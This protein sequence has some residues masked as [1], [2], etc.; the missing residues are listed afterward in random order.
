MGFIDDHG[1]P[2]GDWNHEDFGRTFYQIEK[3]GDVP[4]DLSK[5]EP[6]ATNGGERYEPNHVD[7]QGKPAPILE[8]PLGKF[9]AALANKNFK[10][11]KAALENADPL[12]KSVGNRALRDAYVKSIDGILIKPESEGGYGYG[13]TP[14]DVKAIE[15]G[16]EQILNPDGSIKDDLT[17]EDAEIHFRELGGFD[18]EGKSTARPTKNQIKMDTAKFYRDR[19]SGEMIRMGMKEED[20]AKRMASQGYLEEPESY[21]SGTLGKM[22]KDYSLALQTKGNKIDSEKL[23]KSW[24]EDGKNTI[25]PSGNAGDRYDEIKGN[26]RKMYKPGGASDKPNQ[27]FEAARQR[28]YGADQQ[29]KNLSLQEREIAIREESNE[30]SREDSASRRNLERDKMKQDHEHFLADQEQKKVDAIENRKLQR[31]QMQQQMMATVLQIFGQFVTTAMT[32]QGQVASAHISG[33]YQMQAS[34]MGKFKNS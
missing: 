14:E 31:E 7:E 23:A 2:K 34:I 26:M 13:F 30:I 27:D 32:V 16:R 21:P 4:T 25:K 20:G 9:R 5:V 28:L 10:E 8:G 12:T 15:V 18:P 1:N 17:V 19:L 22:Q 6:R 29:K 3:T 33:Q 11:A 24:M